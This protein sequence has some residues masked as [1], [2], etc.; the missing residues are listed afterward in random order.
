[1]YKNRASN[2]RGGKGS[3][4]KDNDFIKLQKL[5]SGSFGVVYTCKRI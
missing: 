3:R 1:M 4:S 2:Q 5:G